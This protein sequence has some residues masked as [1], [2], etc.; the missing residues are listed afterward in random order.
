VRLTSKL[1]PDVGTS[2]AN[3]LSA[4]F[5]L[6]FNQMPAVGNALHQRLEKWQGALRLKLL[7]NNPYVPHEYRLQQW[8][9]QTIEDNPEQLLSDAE[10]FYRTAGK[11]FSRHFWAGKLGL[12]TESD[13]QLEKIVLAWR[14]LLDDWRKSLDLALSDWQLSW[15]QEQ[16]QQLLNDLEAWLALLEQLRENLEQLGLEPGL[17]FDLSAGELTPGEIEQFKRWASYFSQDKGA[18]AISELLGRMRQASQSQRIER[19]RCQRLT[20][21]QTIDIDSSE[22]IIGLRLGKSLEHTLPGELAL[23]TSPDTAILFDLKYLESRLLCFEM[24][25]IAETLQEEMYE[26]DFSISEDELLGPM[27]VCIDTSGSMQGQP[28]YLAKAMALFLASK[29]KKTNRLCYIINFSTRIDCFEATG[30]GSLSTLIHFLMQ[31]FHGGTDAVPALRHAIETMQLE[32]YQRADLLMISD[33]IMHELPADVRD[34][35]GMARIN[36]NRFHSLVIGDCF[37]HTKLTTHF[38]KEWVFNPATQG[39]QELVRF[40]PVAM[41]TPN[42][43][44]TGN[45]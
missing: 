4:R 3:E 28:E 29:A 12:L 31:S 8:Q 21:V 11:P 18:K 9:G 35:I 14:T 27:I 38:D 17:W 6:L 32:S 26:E 19:V 5:P 2:I 41:P 23:L 39:I 1:I 43:F 34:T 16:R 20:P 44:R 33:F 13:C 30:E 36:G 10:D 22:E 25:G 42:S 45:H 37:L 24:Q 15:L 7:R 40:N